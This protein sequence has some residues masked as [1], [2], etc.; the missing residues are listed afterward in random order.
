[1]RRDSNQLVPR[2]AR[3]GTLPE[4]PIQQAQFPLLGVPYFLQI[5]MGRGFSSTNFVHWINGVESDSVESDSKGQQAGP[6]PDTKC[7][8]RT[9]A[10]NSMARPSR[11]EL[12]N[13]QYFELLF[14]S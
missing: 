1:M 12:A 2:H 5:R 9:A 6:D 3:R 7:D 14:Q 13:G 8:L 4:L 11:L 10:W